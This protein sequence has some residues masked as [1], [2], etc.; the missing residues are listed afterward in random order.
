MS[1]QIHIRL[2]DNVFDELTSYADESGQSVQNCVSGVLIKMLNQQKPRKKEKASFTFIDLFAGIGGMRIAF[3]QAG[4]R[5]V[6]SSEWNKYSQQTYLANLESSRKAI[7][8]RW[9]Q[10]P[11]RIMTFWWLV[12]RASLSQLPACPKTEPWTEQRA[13][14]IRHRERCFL[15]SAAF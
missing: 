7:L 4:G 8:P 15:M 12:F 2:E 9:T 14:R 1:K 6:Y 3:D 10:I 13:L 11:F 5:C